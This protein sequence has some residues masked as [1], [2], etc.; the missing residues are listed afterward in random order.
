MV[1]R[2]EFSN[3]S[4]A[5]AVD[6][7]NFENWLRF[8]YAFLMKFAGAY[9][10]ILVPQPLVGETAALVQEETLM[11]IWIMKMMITKCLSPIRRGNAMTTFTDQDSVISSSRLGRH[12]P[13]WYHQTSVKGHHLKDQIEISQ[14]EEVKVGE[15]VGESQLYLKNQL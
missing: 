12:L 6:T 7:V 15:A 13:G 4:S 3:R 5:A 14:E 9:E 8:F 2:D 11:K 1:A 10:A